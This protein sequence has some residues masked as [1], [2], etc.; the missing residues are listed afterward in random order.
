MCLQF[1]YKLFWCQELN[2]SKILFKTGVFTRLSGSLWYN[3]FCSSRLRCLPPSQVFWQSKKGYCAGGVKN[4]M[5][6]D[7]RT[8][9]WASTGLVLLLSKL[10]VSVFTVCLFGFLQADSYPD[11]SF[12]CSFCD[13]NNKDI[14]Q[15]CHILRIKTFKILIN[16]KIEFFH[17]FY[18]L[19]NIQKMALL[20]LYLKEHIIHVMKLSDWL[21]NRLT[22]ILFN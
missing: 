3:S 7:I 10:S 20:L 4:H 15:V 18:Y 17:L 6:T 9:R 16:I 19:V 22:F 2:A 21:R 13:S 12:Q 11:D 14:L 5:K 8:V 1:C